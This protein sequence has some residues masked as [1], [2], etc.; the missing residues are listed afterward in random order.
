MKSVEDLAGCATD[1]LLGWTE[2]KGT[3]TIR[4][5]GYLEGFELSREDAESL[6]M[7]ARVKAGWIEAPLASDEAEV[8]AEA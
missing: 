2:R 8:A 1:D 6:I 4:N 7:D 3:E 5:A